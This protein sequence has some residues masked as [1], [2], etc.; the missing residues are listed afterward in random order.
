LSPA[1]P[2][3]LV[4]GAA[5]RPHYLGPRDEAWLTLLLEEHARFV[6]RKRIELRERLREPL[7][8]RAPR[9]KLRLAVQLLERLVPDADAPRLVPRD[10][11]ARVFRA[12]ASVPGSRADVLVAVAAEL[13]TSADELEACLLCDLAGQRRLGAVPAE[14]TAAHLS[15]LL[16]YELVTRLLKR[17]STVRFHVAAG[18]G[19]L[20]RKA[21]RLGL[22]CRVVRDSPSGESVIVELS[23]PFALFRRTALYAR[24]LGSLL[25]HAAACASFVLEAHCAAKRGQLACTFVV[26]ATDPIFP[27]RALP[28]DARGLDRRFA[29]D[30]ARL[31]S[32]WRISHEP[33]PLAAPGSLLFP[34]FEL[35]HTRDPSRRFLLEILG[36]WTHHYLAEKLA[37]YRSAGVENVILCVDERRCCSEAELPPRA[38]VLPFK[39]RIDAAR[40]LELLL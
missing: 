16:N 11:R 6:G 36:F 28:S 17:A 39:N 31:T 26:H 25:P 24:A 9:A 35:V 18:A 13:G 38:R 5:L 1:L 33:R 2:S 40:L 37:H 23:G 12:A 27:L 14:L 32:E 19:T 7:P 3:A 8:L 20:A 29:R 21:Q 4:P 34:D 10:V 22:I 15:L 30:F